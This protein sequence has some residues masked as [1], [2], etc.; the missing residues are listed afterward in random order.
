MSDAAVSRCASGGDDRGFEEAA[1]IGGAFFKF[2]FEVAEISE[3]TEE[4]SEWSGRYRG[5]GVG[6]FRGVEGVYSF[7]LIDFFCA[8]IGDDTVEVES[9]AEFGVCGIVCGGARKDE[10]C[11]VVLG[12]GF[13]DVSGVGGEEERD[14]VRR[15][16]PEGRVSAGEGGADDSELV[17]LDGVKHAHTGIGVVAAE[18]DDFGGL[19]VGKNRVELEKS[20]DER[21]RDTGLQ[22]IVL[23][24]ALIVAVGADSLFAEY[25][26]GFIE[27]KKST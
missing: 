16:V 10:T 4:V 17:V 12:E 27:L 14:V 24:G 11:G 23:V 18:Q 19:T 20:P 6:G 22:N 26:I 8:V 1:V 9:D 5:L 21:K 15:N 7:S 2:I 3:F 13:G 25:G